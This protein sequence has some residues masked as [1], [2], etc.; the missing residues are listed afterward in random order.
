MSKHTLGPWKAKGEKYG[1][2]ID[3]FGNDGTDQPIAWADSDD[4]DPKEAKANARLIAA[5]PDLLA[6]LERLFKQTSE[7][8]A[9]CG[10]DTREAVRA[11]IAKAAG[12]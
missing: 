6:A 10:E 8:N 3:I 2:T 1:K 9:P 12:K 7:G 11:A 5:A 4:I